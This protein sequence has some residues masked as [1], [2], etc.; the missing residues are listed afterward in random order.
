MATTVEVTQI[1]DA[2]GLILPK[3]LLERMRLRA[4]DRVQLAETA[5]GWTLRP[6]RSEFDRQMEIANRIMRENHDLLRR[7]AE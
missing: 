7:L 6:D 1:G 2:A 4:G 3:E 5:D